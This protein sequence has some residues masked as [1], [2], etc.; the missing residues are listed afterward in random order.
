M[1][2]RNLLITWQ[3]Q[4]PYLGRMNGTNEFIQAGINKILNLPTPLLNIFWG[5]LKPL[6]LSKGDYFISE[7]NLCNKL[8]LV[9]KGAFYSY[10]QKEAKEVIEGF[11]FEGCFMADYPS[12]IH[13]TFSKKNFKALENSEVLTISYQELAQLY[14]DN[15][16]FERAGRLMAEYLFAQWELKLQDTIFLS[17]TERYLN[18]LKAGNQTI[19]RVPQYLIASY[20]NITPQYLSQIRKSITS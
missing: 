6:S 10:Y 1:N 14:Q 17:P 19:Q 8:A 5:K 3:S 18:L 4:Q 16:L 15:I 9:I 7:G 12:F 13:K 11:C 20:L 2:E